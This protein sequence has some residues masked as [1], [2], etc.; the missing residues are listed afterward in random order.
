MKAAGLITEYNPLHN[1][2]MHHLDMARKESGIDCT[3]AVMSGNFVQRGEPAIIDKHSRCTAAINAGVNLCVELPTYY[4]V[5]SAEGFADGAV[6]TLDALKADAVVF[7]SECSD[8]EVLT[9][10]ATILATEPEMYRELLKDNLATGLSYPAARQSALIE[11]CL[12]QGIK[13]PDNLLSSPNNILGIEYIKSIIRN[14]CNITPVAISRSG[15]G[16]NDIDIDGLP[17]ASAV[18]HI[19]AEK[20]SKVPQGTESMDLSELKGLLPLSMYELFLKST[21]PVQKETPILVD[22]MTPLFNYKMSELFNDCSRDKKL[23]S[24]KLSSYTDIT[25]ELANRMAEQFS[26]L[27]LISEYCQRVKSR[28][29]TY[30]RISRCILHVILDI[31]KIKAAKYDQPNVPY[32]R[33]LGFDEKGQ[34]YLSSIKKSCPVPII[35]KTANH[36]ELLADDIHCSAIY[37]QLVFNKYGTVLK[38]EFRSGVYI[39]PKSV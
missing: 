27:D 18:R 35:T 25:T 39:K 22:D 33:V 24:A 29:Y 21:H 12:S 20:A 6:R 15:T 16:Y 3:I 19:I 11:H 10:A 23:L 8:I 13:L 17:S 4:A 32:I 5:S 14:K 38:D 7:G 36:R 1:G 31:T 2:H 34:K 28:Q 9:K 37:N 26:G 30:S